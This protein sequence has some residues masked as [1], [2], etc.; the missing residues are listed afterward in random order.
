MFFIILENSTE[1][2]LLNRVS[3]IML[4]FLSAIHVECFARQ[5]DNNWLVTTCFYSLWFNDRLIYQNLLVIRNTYLMKVLT[6]TYLVN[7]LSK[8][9]K[10]ATCCVYLFV[11][12]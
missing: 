2:Y 5:L 4:F 3:F 12:M 8:K 1:I 11:V 10:I 7:V 6:V 9:K